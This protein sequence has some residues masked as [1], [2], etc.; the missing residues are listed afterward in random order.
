[1]LRGAAYHLRLVAYRQT[2]IAPLL[3]FVS[4]VG[5]IYASPAG[6]P[7][8]AGAIPAL[9]LMP[10]S[11]WLTR[12]VATAESEP[13]ADI[14]LVCVGS[15][16]ARRGARALAALA[17]ATGLTAVSVGWAV[18]ANDPARYTASAVLVI[19]AMCMA[20]SVAGVGLGLLLGPPVRT[21]TCVLSLTAIVVASLVVP[22]LPPL[23]PLLR[24][25]ERTGSAAWQVTLA[26]AQALVT[27]ALAAAASAL[28]A[29]EVT[30]GRERV[31]SAAGS[32]R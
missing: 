31:V 21:A 1:M 15:A 27:G 17:L 19:V 14:T 9:A 2:A 6:P 29:R 11:A 22:W 32:S 3:V 16:I 20:E 28:V 18:V 26:V 4:L 13:Y 12:V 23:N 8:S 25:A 24:V 7:V 30:P 5:A 10:V